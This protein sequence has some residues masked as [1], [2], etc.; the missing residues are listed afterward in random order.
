MHL[1]GKCKDCCCEFISDSYSLSVLFIVL[2]IMYLYAF[3]EYVGIDRI[4]SASHITLAVGSLFVSQGKKYMVLG[5]SVAFAETYKHVFRAEPEEVLGV[6]LSDKEIA[7]IHYI[8]STYFALYKNIV[9]L[10]VD[11]PLAVSLV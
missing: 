1:L 11:D 3:D 2:L 4:F 6:L 10:Y 7:M 9:P 5:K 8:A